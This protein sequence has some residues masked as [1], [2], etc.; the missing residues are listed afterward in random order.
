MAKSL[1]NDLSYK[2]L[3]E[4]HKTCY[5]ET[6]RYDHFKNP[7]LSERYFDNYLSY[8]QA[9]DCLDL[10]ADLAYLDREQSTYPKPF[11]HLFFNENTELDSV[12]KDYLVKKGFTLTKHIIFTALIK[13]LKLSHKHQDFVLALVTKTNLADYIAYTY[14]K[15]RQY[16]ESYAEQI[17]A[18]QQKHL[19]HQPCQ[20]YLALKEGVIIG[21]LTAWNYGFFVE[22]DDFEVQKAYRGCGIGSALQFRASRA[23]EHSIL[24]AEEH[25]RAMYE[26]QGYQEVAY[27]WTALKD[28]E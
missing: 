20:V 13:E 27:Y 23:F 18:Y 26:H 8:K 10:Q 7:E 17:K 6:K 21:S 12:V 11:Y 19:L 25:N 15:N 5:W 3:L 28:K 22:M 16:G 2:R 14:Q 9:V 4:S 24:I 1:K